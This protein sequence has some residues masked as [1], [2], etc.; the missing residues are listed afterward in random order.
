MSIDDEGDF[1]RRGSRTAAMIELRVGFLIRGF[2][3]GPYADDQVTGAIGAEAL[4]ATDSSTDLFTR[5]FE[6]LRRN[7]R[8]PRGTAAA[9]PIVTPGRR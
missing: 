6:R 9:P 7:G 5:A 8:M 1:E 3:V 2:D 4:A